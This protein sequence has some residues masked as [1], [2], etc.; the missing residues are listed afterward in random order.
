MTSFQ[1]CLHSDQPLT[2]VGVMNAYCALMAQAAG[3]SALYLSG[4]GVANF[5][6]GLPDLG[7]TSLDDVSIDAGRIVK[8]T[9][10]PLLVDID[11][12]WEEDQGMTTTIQRMIDIGV[13]AVHFEDQ[14]AQKR[15]GHRPN[16]RLVSSEAMC[17]RV[18]EAVAARG[19]NELYLIA[20][21]DAIASEGL[22]AAIARARSYVDAGA[23]AIFMEAVTDL[24]D[25]E[26]ICQSV[27]VPVLANMTE[28]GKTPLCTTDQLAALGV[29]MAL[30]PLTAARAMNH[31]ALTAYDTL[32]REHTQQSL[33]QCMQDRDTLYQHLNYHQHELE[34]DKTINNK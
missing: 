13:A 4:A 8:A 33:L 32:R 23:D 24:N 1:D 5:S 2:I 17:R 18:D 19:Q 15:C 14:I 34:Q 12:G 7:M 25:F 30:Y 27:P 31:A 28:F 3:F 29:S 6:Y 9:R 21:T 22:A 20:R 10:C 11:T 26:Q 16:K